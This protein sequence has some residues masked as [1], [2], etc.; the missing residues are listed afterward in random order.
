MS[1]VQDH[2][3]ECP[4]GPANFLRVAVAAAG[5]HVAGG[6]DAEMMD[7]ELSGALMD[8]LAHYAELPDWPS[9]TLGDVAAMAFHGR[10]IG[11]HLMAHCT[12]GAGLAGPSR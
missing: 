10:P 5:H 7:R 12:C 1:E 11:E 6:D 3:G 2:T 8:A 9:A 4:Y